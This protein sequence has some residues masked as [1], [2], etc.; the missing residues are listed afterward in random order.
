M[1]STTLLRKKPL[2]AF[3]RVLQSSKLKRTFGKW[4]L[5]AIGVGA[6]I[7]GGIFVLKGVAAG[8]ECNRHPRLLPVQFKTKSLTAKK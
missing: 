6:V 2:D 8:M 4:E 5:A 7:G 1:K 3:P